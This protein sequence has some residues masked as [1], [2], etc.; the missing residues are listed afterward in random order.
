MYL[1]N[2][3]FFDG[4]PNVSVTQADKIYA[5][6]IEQV[7]IK[8][9]DFP[10]DEES[11]K[12]AIGDENLCS[13]M[14]RLDRRVVGW[15]VFHVEADN[16]YIDRIAVVD[17]EHLGHILSSIIETITWSPAPLDRPTL[18]TVVWPEHEIDRPVFTH[19]TG[20]GW[21]AV[22]CE[23]DRY[24]GYGSKFDGILLQKRF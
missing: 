9:R 12:V 23:R 2:D 18:V 24:E 14:A 13:V 17:G 1:D 8:S 6:Q 22:G 19:L 5:G 3:G 4:P 16:I 11:I 21:R 20:S 10:L 15:S 7:E